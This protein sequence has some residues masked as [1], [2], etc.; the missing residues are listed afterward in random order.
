MSYLTALRRF[1]VNVRLFLIA[2]AVIGFTNFGGIFAALFNLYMLR[3]GYGTQF[4]GTLN[5][6]SSLTLMAFCLPAIA[7][8][9]RFGSRRTILAGLVINIVSSVLIQGAI[10]IPASW[11]SA[12]LLISYGINSV[13][14]AFYLVAS[15]PFLAASTTTLE[16]GHAFS[17]QAALWPL[18]GFGG[19]LLGGMI[20]G[21]VNR[22][23]GIPLTSAGPYQI[24]LWISAVISVFALLVMLPTSQPQSDTSEQ[25]QYQENKRRISSSKSRSFIFSGLNPLQ[26]IVLLS[27]IVTI[28]VPGEGSI[29]SFFNVYL[30]NGLSLPT[31]WIGLILGFG[32]L[33]AGMGALLTPLFTARLGNARTYILFTLATSIC[34]L[35]LIFL[36]T[37]YG[38]SLGYMGTIMMVQIARPALITI[39]M[40]SVPA[41][42]RASMSAVTTIAASLSF[43]LIGLLGGYMIPSNGYPAFFL[44][45]ALFTT[46]AGAGSWVYLRMQKA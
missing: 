11:R 43:G 37:W 3:L 45:S 40:E 10:F 33:I 44:L 30:D 26:I 41:D 35:P 16:R 6:V 4:I 5:A 12:F 32:Q 8:E 7:L 28:Q 27:L 36:P 22:F 2:A 42:Y 14:L 29:R 20:P 15:Q 13:G 23:T 9:R 34:M 38:A 39:Q 19:S 18:S 17:V 1:N 46:L 21:L 25:D 31:T 24:A